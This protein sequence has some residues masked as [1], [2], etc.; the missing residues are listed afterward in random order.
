[1]TQMREYSV[2]TIATFIFFLA[3]MIAFF[4]ESS[5]RSRSADK[6]GIVFFSSNDCPH[7]RTIKNELRRIQRLYPVKLWTFNID[8]PKAY[9]LFTKLE[10]IHSSDGFGVPLIMLDE[11]ILMGEAEIKKRLEPTVRRLMKSG[12]SPLPYLGP[13]TPKKRARKRTPP[14]CPTCDRRPPTLGEE[15]GK[16]Q[17]FVDKLF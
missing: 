5:A 9:E 15:W 1:M 3:L 6:V 2:F 13:T 12:G 17:T 8:N 16:I 14:R 11:S 4:Q 10:S 7:C